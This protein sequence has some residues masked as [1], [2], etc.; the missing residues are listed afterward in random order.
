MSFV[1]FSSRE[2]VCRFRRSYLLISCFLVYYVQWTE[3]VIARRKKYYTEDRG[4]IASSIVPRIHIATATCVTSLIN[5]KYIINMLMCKCKFCVSP[6][7]TLLLEISTYVI[8]LHQRKDTSWI[9]CLRWLNPKKLTS[10]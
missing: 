4:F 5:Y 1:W 9:K 8:I 2:H 10:V 7:I 3:C 6:Y